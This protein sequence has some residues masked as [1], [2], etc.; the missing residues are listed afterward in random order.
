MQQFSFGRLSDGREVTA[1][2]L[3][4]HTGAE[5][6]I[7]DYGCTVQSLKVPNRFGTATDVVLGYQTAAEYEAN[8]GYFGAVVG[9]VGNRI[10]ASSFSLDG[11][12]YRLAANEGRNHLHGGVN[13]FDRRFWD[14]EASGERVVF[15]RIS[16]DGEEGYPGSLVVRVAYELQEGNKLLITYD[17]VSDS[18]TPVNLTNHSYFNLHGGGDIR[19]HTLQLNAQLFAEIDGELLPTGWLSPVAGTPLDFTSPKEVG[20]DLGAEFEQ[21]RL[22]GGYDHNFVL[23]HS[24]PVQPSARLV[25]PDTGIVMTVE[26][27]APGIQVYS[28]NAIQ[29]R[30]GK[31]GAVL[32]AHSGIC[33]ETQNFP[34]AVH[35]S[36]FPNSIL[37]PGSRY[38]SHTSYGF[39]LI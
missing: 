3:Q 17:A 8:D 15:S 9:R 11:K 10:G 4:N 13:G 6:V 5:A 38:Q 21:M 2:R 36:N 37:R 18:A 14:A 19:S 29:P 1:Y 24:I 31:D 20:R 27:A 32:T 7:L 26:T 23:D 28:G 34:D 35:H 12:T 25:G 33:L 30:R 22:A 16:P 39:S